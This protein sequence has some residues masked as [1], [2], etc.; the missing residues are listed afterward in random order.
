MDTA[1]DMESRMS[2][3]E[4]TFSKVQEKITNLEHR[5]ASVKRGR[6]MENDELD[7]PT[8][9]VKSQKMSDTFHARGRPKGLTND[10]LQKRLEEDRI[11]R[12][13]DRKERFSVKDVVTRKVTNLF[14]KD[15]DKEK[16][17]EDDN[18]ED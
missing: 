17:K 11:K 8:D 16:D 2:I 6:D 10:V 13:I 14:S 9:N 4:D 18:M 7:R 1:N 12:D 5:R 3:L 15:K